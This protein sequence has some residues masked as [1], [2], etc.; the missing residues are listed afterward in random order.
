M[1]RIQGL[2]E[3]PFSADQLVKTGEGY[4]F[5][6][7]LA[8]QGAVAGQAVVLRDGVDNTAAF[9]VPFIFPTAAG[10]LSRE[11]ANGKKFS[12]GLF[13]DLQGGGQI[14]GEMTY[15]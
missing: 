11:W 8:W 10:T 15:K 12:T 7:T 14:Q 3:L 2:A 4:V 9:M 6:I 1:P 5:S 13:I